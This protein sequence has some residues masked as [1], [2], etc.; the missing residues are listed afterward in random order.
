MKYQ[1]KLKATAM[2]GF[3]L[4]TQFSA[5]RDGTSKPRRQ[6]FL[7][8]YLG[9]LDF[10]ALQEHLSAVSYSQQTLNRSHDS[11][12]KLVKFCSHVHKQNA[13]AQD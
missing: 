12:Y 10:Q 7:K 9:E 13:A 6:G 1:K 4:T 5:G 11:N 2:A 3:D 8:N